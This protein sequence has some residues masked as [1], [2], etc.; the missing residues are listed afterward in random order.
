MT[1]WVF[2]EQAAARD[3]M[4]IGDSI[5]RYDGAIEKHKM[6]SVCMLPE[7]TVH[8]AASGSMFI[9]HGA[10]RRLSEDEVRFL[11]LVADQMALAIDDAR[12]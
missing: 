5:P 1:C 6:Q 7:T 12:T 2:Q 4:W 9:T 8:R 11:G 10:F 3:S